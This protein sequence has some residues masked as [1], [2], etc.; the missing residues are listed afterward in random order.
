MLGRTF[1]ICA[2]AAL[3]PLLA[4]CATFQLTG[5]WQNPHVPPP[6]YSSVVVLATA[7][8][9]TSRNIFEDAFASLA[10]SHGIRAVQGY[11]VVT[12]S[13]TMTQPELEAG[14]RKSGAQ[15]AI[16]ANVIRSSVTTQ[17]GPTYTDPNGGPNW[18]V[19]Y[20]GYYSTG[21]MEWSPTST[22]TTM[23]VQLRVNVY[24]AASQQLVWSAITNTV[25][26]DQVTSQAVPLAQMLFDALYSRTILVA[27]QP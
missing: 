3:M 19:G 26:Q 12:E 7:R 8:E 11:S 4:G 13:Q 2:T 18:E 16:V 5:T 14:I 25:A 22:T 10:Q 6:H 24:D 1:R 21:W 15:A 27:A 20:W 9:T 17:T 23:M